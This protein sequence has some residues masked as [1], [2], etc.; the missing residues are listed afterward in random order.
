MRDSTHDHGWGT[1]TPRSCIVSTKS[2]YEIPCS[3]NE[4]MPGWS[5]LGS[6]A[7]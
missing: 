2:R 4:H 6:E 1:S 7:A 3:T 5:R